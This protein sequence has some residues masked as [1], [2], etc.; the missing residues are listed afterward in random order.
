MEKT[1]LFDVSRPKSMGKRG[2]RAPFRGPRLYK[3]RFRVQVESGLT[4][5]FIC[6]GCGSYDE[7]DDHLDFHE[8]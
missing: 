7:E 6:R 2:F 3:C 1:V 8:A 4:T 5:D